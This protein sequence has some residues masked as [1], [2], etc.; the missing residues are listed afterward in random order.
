VFERYGDADAAVEHF[1]NIGQL[2]APLMETATVTGEVLGTPK[3]EMRKP[4]RRSAEAVHPVADMQ[5]EAGGLA[6]ELL[7]QVGLDRRAAEMRVDVRIALA[8]EDLADLVD[9]GGAARQLEGAFDDVLGGHGRPKKFRPRHERFAPRSV[10]HALFPYPDQRL[11]QRLQE[12]R[13]VG[14]AGLTAALPIC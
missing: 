8:P 1:G 13:P 12:P 5:Q 7:L 2:M 14:L 10:P 4:H 9:V 3:A 6:D 11:I